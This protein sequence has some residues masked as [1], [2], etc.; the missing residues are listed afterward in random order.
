MKAVEELRKDVLKKIDVQIGD[1]YKK[2]DFISE[3][4]TQKVAL[5]K[6]KIGVW[7]NIIQNSFLTNIKLLIS[8]PFIYGISVFILLFH[9]ALELYH[10]VCFR[11]YK[12]PLVKPSDYFIFDRAHLPYLN[13][14]EK[15]NCAYCSYY[16]NLIA[17][18]REIGA[19]TER[20]WCPIKHSMPRKDAHS[21][22]SRFVDYSNAEELRKEWE[23]LRKFDDD[24]KTKL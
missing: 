8:A 2:R 11:L 15:I 16:N 5:K 19:R 20:Y 12:I 18:A 1:L 17:Y 10:Q 22:Y 24:K 3:I 21:H 4:F 9:I 13:W 6:K 14:L 23:N 7:K